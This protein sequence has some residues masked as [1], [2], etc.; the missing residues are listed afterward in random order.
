ML[1]AMLKAKELNSLSK[2]ESAFFA[3]KWIIKN[4]T[5]YYNLG[6]NDYVN[7]VYETGEGSPWGISTLFTHICNFLSI[8]SKSIEG[9]VK[10]SSR[11]F[12]DGLVM[13]KNESS[14]NYIVIDG[15]N[16]LVDA[17]LGAGMYNEEEFHWLNSDLF[18]ATKPE[19]FI[20]YHFPNDIKW[21][22]LYQTITM[23]KFESIPFVYRFFYL[24][25][26]KNFYPYNFG[27]KSNQEIKIELAYD[28]LIEGTSLSTS[29]F[30]EASY[31]D[32]NCSI[33]N[34]NLK[35]EITLK[36]SHSEVLYFVIYGLLNDGDS[37]PLIIY[38]LIP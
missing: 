25:G 18:F 6:K 4:I 19:I 30:N 32:K 23:E 10:M 24:F 35:F 15:H 8:E 3:Y 33:V 37:L 11:N 17:S 2:A 20:N 13:S 38:K 16:Y 34:S 21:Q 31:K 14:W 28:Q 12:E 29:L 7:K 9:Y 22:L 27:I 5:V 26:F 36:E 1:M